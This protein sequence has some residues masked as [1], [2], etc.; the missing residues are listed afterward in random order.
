MGLQCTWGRSGLIALV[1]TPETTVRPP[2]EHHSVAHP[3]RMPVCC[4]LRCVLRCA[5]RFASRFALCFVLRFAF[6]LVSSVFCCV[7][8]FA[9]CFVW[10]F[11]FRC[12]KSQPLR[13][14]TIDTLLL[15]MT[16]PTCNLSSAFHLL[17][18]W[19]P[20]VCHWAYHVTYQLARQPCNGK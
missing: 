7:L 15:K 10:C 9:L 8:C 20:A 13:T 3:R 1:I 11:A 12:S 16:F 5:M 17:D 19:P 6:C 14:H 18:S 2:V 4:V